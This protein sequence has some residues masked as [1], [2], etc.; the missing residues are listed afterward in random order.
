MLENMRRRK[1]DMR[2]NMCRHKT[3]MCKKRVK[4]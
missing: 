1:L 4:K 2:K 3:D